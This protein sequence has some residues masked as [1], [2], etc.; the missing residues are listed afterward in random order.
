[1]KLDKT[2]LDLAMGRKC[3]MRSDVAETVGISRHT[4]S[5]IYNGYECRPATAGKI[6]QA[7]GVDL[8]EIMEEVKP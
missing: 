5:R 2:R 4:L 1:M 8:T 3:M 6:A 7:L